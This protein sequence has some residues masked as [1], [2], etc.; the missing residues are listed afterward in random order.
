M[1]C[2]SLLDSVQKSSRARALPKETLCQHEA[3]PAYELLSLHACY[4]CSGMI[5]WHAILDRKGLALEP[6]PFVLHARCE[7]RAIEACRIFVKSFWRPA[8]CPSASSA[9]CSR[10]QALVLPA[11][12]SQS[13]ATISVSLSLMAKKGRR[14]AHISLPGIDFGLPLSQCSLFPPRRLRVPSHVG[15]EGVCAPALVHLEARFRPTGPMNSRISKRAPSLRPRHAGLAQRDARSLQRRQKLEHLQPQSCSELLSGEFAEPRWHISNTMLR[16][17]VSLVAKNTSRFRCPAPGGS[18]P[19]VV[20]LPT[21]NLCR[22]TV[23]G[24]S[25]SVLTAVNTRFPEV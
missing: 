13:E 5:S 12:W 4:A 6:W 3:P 23:R 9:F 18:C 11:R 14:L 16:T 22:K 10:R 2:C 8:A 25:T 7:S 17:S 20:L 1:D 19:I 24:D 15:L 21:F